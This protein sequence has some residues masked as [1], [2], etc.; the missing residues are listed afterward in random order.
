MKKLYFFL[1]PLYFLAQEPCI[2]LKPNIPCTT[3]PLLFTNFDVLYW[4]AKESG[5]EYAIENDAANNNL[6]GNI[7]EPEFRFKA[8][9]RFAL[10]FHLPY[11]HW[12]LGFQVTHFDAKSK[13]DQTQDEI[14]QPPTPAGRGLVPVWT[15]PASF[16]S[17]LNDVRWQFANNKWKINYNIIDAKLGT[18]LCISP[19][20][21]VR[22]C[23]GIKNSII[24]QNFTVRYEQ[25]NVLPGNITPLATSTSMRNFSYGI[26]PLVGFDTKWQASTMWSFFTS[27]SCALL[28]THFELNRIEN[29][30]STTLNDRA[31]FHAKFWTYKP[32]IDAAIGVNLD[33]CS[34]RTQYI[35]ISAAY[36][37]QY[38]FKQN[39]MIRF[40]DSNIAGKTRNTLG[41][42]FLHGL[43][44]NLHFNY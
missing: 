40:I 4:Q 33:I 38:W 31:E 29:D 42:L 43:S 25:G 7:I 14:D 3:P 30:L 19:A 15:H 22:P 13:K 9:F 17:N 28:H 41:D 5:L 24:H 32:Q 35:A 44:V 39:Q 21:S 26:G 1:L 11:D 2:V 20:L 36:E 6:D 23:F 27:L 10:G 12:T 8:G 18:L 34:G 16:A 37:M